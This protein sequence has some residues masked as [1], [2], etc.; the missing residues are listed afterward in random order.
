MGMMIQV[1]KLNGEISIIKELMIYKLDS[2][3]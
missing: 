3:D 1:Q 2:N